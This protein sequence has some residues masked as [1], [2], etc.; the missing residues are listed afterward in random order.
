M[1]IQ[2]L[3]SFIAGLFI[4]LT[5]SLPLGNL[6]VAAMQIAAR[7]TLRKALWFAAGVTLVEMAYLAVTLSIV[8]SFTIQARVF[9]FF[10]LVSVDIL[11]IMAAGSF[12]ATA[13]KEGKNVILDNKVKRFLLGAGMSAVNPMQIPFWAGWSIYLLSQV[14]LENN[15]AG[16]TIFTLSAGAGTFIALLIF[17]LAGRRF[18]AVM[19]QNKKTV[20]A[21]MGILFVAMAVYQFIKLF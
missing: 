7:E 14:W 15:V 18:S 8:G 2:Y 4:S 1:A 20:N 6:N 16:N 9:F 19:Q 17:I 21:G 10:R 12:M 11:L 5:G 13:N 3:Q